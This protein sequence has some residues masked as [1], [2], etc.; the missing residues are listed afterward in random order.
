MAVFLTVVALLFM[1]FAGASTLGGPNWFGRTSELTDYTF[2]VNPGPPESYSVT[3]RVTAQPVKQGNLLPDVVIAALKDQKTGLQAREQSL[4]DSITRL[5]ALKARTETLQKLDEQALL[6]RQ[7]QFRDQLA[8]LQ[9]QITESHD[10]M[11][12]VVIQTS[13]L[14]QKLGLRTEDVLRLRDQLAA[15]RADHERL[16]EQKE[17]LVD[18]LILLEGNIDQLQRRKEQLEAEQPAQKVSAPSRS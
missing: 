17:L 13:Q 18:V 1:A 16:V 10:Q 11:T 3:N 2:T 5:Q 8:G 6:A 14:N 12:Q 7:Q 9:Q 15:L 4:D